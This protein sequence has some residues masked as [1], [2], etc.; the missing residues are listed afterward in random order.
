[1][2][3]NKK[4]KK[5]TIYL[6]YIVGLNIPALL[7]LPHELATPWPAI[8]QDIIGHNIQELTDIANAPVIFRNFLA[9]IR[10]I[11]SP[12]DRK[13]ASYELVPGITGFACDHI[14]G[15]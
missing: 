1:M 5:N 3:G 6:R 8:K 2:V 7:F 9:K 13:M 4:A 15:I 11:N 10:Y 12:E 14:E